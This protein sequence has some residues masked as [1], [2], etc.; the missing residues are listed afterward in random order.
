MTDKESGDWASYQKLVLFQLEEQS[1]EIRILAQ[2]ILE[3]KLDITKLQMKAGVWGA[4]T[5]M[6]P[7]VI[8]LIWVMLRD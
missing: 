3:L 4:M 8:A 7:G 1:K 5:G 6:I 2:S